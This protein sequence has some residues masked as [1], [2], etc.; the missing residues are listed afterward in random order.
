MLPTAFTV[1]TEDYLLTRR[2]YLY[3]LPKPRTPLV[4]ELVSFATSPAGQEVVRDSGF[5]ELT[6]M[7]RDGEHCDDR[8]P[9]PYAAA[10]AGAKRVSL[11]FRFR[12]GGNALDSRASHDLDRLVQLLH[13]YPRAK[14]L[15]FGFSATS[16]NPDADTAVSRQRARAVAR[17]LEQRGVIA[18]LIDG[19]GDALPVASNDTEAG[20]QR[21][22]R[23][24]VWMTGGT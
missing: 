10:I 24:E 8:C 22:R 20:R 4:A 7:L 18:Y 11:D 12:A 19:F 2:L 1:T 23:V 9:K 14:L 6:P 13:A 5:V 15:L 21:N 16:G 17:E 3:T